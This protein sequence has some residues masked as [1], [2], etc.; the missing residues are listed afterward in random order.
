MM[1]TKILI[2][3]ASVIPKKLKEE[4]SF[5]CS[6][7]EN[8]YELRSALQG[9]EGDK[10]IVAFLPFLE[11]RHFELYT[12]IQKTTPHV[13][14]VFVVNE[15]SSNMKLKLK[16]NKDFI[17]LWRTEE[18]QIKENI[19]TYL[20]GRDIRLRQDRREPHP[21][22][23]LLSPSLLPQGTANKGFQP[24]LGGSFENLSAHGSCL[25]IKAPFYDKKDFVNLTYQTNEGE[26][27]TLE[28]QV[29]WAKW[30]EKEQTQELG[31]HFVST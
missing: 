18:G 14:T 24:I 29:R 8:P 16:H 5:E 17:V 3:G 13:K 26:F 25:R 20:E 7:V 6:L 27:V 23:A 28:G 2:T 11:I 9:S 31:V 30:N 21:M 4:K 22:K 1:K 12:F 10:I 15:L 19:M